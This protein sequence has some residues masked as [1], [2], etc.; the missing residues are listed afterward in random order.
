MHRHL[1]WLGRNI[2]ILAL[3]LC[4]Y[5]YA[6]D[7]GLDGAYLHR[8]GWKCALAFIRV[9]DPKRFWRLLVAPVSLFRFAELHFAAQAVGWRGNIRVLDVGSPR[10]LS[11]YL[12]SRHPGMRLAVTNPD[13]RDL[14]ETQHL[15][16]TCLPR[17]ANVQFRRDRVADLPYARDSFDV[18][19][20]ISVIEHVLAEEQEGFLTVLWGLLRPGGGADPDGPCGGS[21]QGGGEASGHV[22]SG[23]PAQREGRGVLPAGVRLRFPEAA[24][25]VACG[26][27]GG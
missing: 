3:S 6:V 8:F 20:A 18:I 4:G 16:R 9:G 10:L 7:R 23:V 12:L 24:D 2:R 15:Y 22:L 17:C 27:N 5:L 14:A 13:A 21:L 26:G 11:A 25:R 19:Y 1:R